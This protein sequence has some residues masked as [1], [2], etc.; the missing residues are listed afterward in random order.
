MRLIGK[1]EYQPWLGGRLS[2]PNIIPSL[3]ELNRYPGYR[4][5]LIARHEPAHFVRSRFLLFLLYPGV[6]VKAV[7]QDDGFLESFRWRKPGTGRAGYDG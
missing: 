2:C 6:T 5:V 3:I 4:I 7:A 1:V